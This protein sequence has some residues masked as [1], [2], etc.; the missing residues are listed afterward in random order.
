MD[1][2]IDPMD[3]YHYPA[4][5]AWFV[6]LTLIQC[7]FFAKRMKIGRFENQVGKNIEAETSTT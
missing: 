7:F 5:I 4:D 3:N 6:L 1:N 2:A